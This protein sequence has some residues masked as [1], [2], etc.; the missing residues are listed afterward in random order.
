MKL[1]IYTI[2]ILAVVI[3]QLMVEYLYMPWIKHSQYAHSERVQKQKKI[4]EMKQNKCKTKR[5]TKQSTEETEKIRQIAR[6]KSMKKKDKKKQKRENHRN[7][8]TNEI[9]H[10]IFPGKLNSVRRKWRSMAFVTIEIC[11]FCRNW[12]K[13]TKRWKKNTSFRQTIA[14]WKVIFGSL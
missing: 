10:D 12:A 11:S 9:I 14:N 5:K 13:E 2:S 1:V 6:A 7:E 4:F 8:R 3:H